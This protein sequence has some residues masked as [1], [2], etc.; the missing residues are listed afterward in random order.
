D[1]ARF[2]GTYETSILPD[3]DCCT[4]FVPRTPSTA[5]PIHLAERQE[6]ALDVAGLVHQAVEAAEVFEYHEPSLTE[7]KKVW[8][9]KRLVV[10]LDSEDPWRPS[11][12]R[13]CPS[14]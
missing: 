11:R 2:I 6:S 3:E 5:V 1:Q 12:K 14:A 13:R 8:T 9:K 10:D 4:L 7:A